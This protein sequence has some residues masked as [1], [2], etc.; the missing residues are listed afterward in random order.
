MKKFFVS[1]LLVIFVTS[2]FAGVQEKLEKFG[3]DNGKEY[4]KPFVTSY[5]TNFNSG[6]FNTA[7][8][9]KPFRF[10][11]MVNMMLAFVPDE[12]KTF[13]P[14]R[15]DLSME[16]NTQTYYLY[17]EPTGETA[18]VFGKDGGTII[19]NPDLD[20]I[21]GLDVSNLD[22]DLPNGGNLPAVPLMVPQLNVGLPAGNELMIRGLPKFEVNKDIGEVGF[23]GI[24]LKHSV[25]QYI[26]LIPIDIAI[27]GAYQ[28]MVVGD[29][30]ELNNFAVNAEISK[31]LLMWTLYGGL[32]YEST[33]LT[34]DY[35]TEIMFYNED[36]TSFDLQPLDIDFE[37]EGD[38]N[39]R[40]TFGVRYSLL[41][42]KLYADYTISKYSV[43]NAGIGI[44]F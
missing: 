8:V 42:L 20:A 41:L 44:S 9:L 24:G 37:I 29:I 3:E 18:T 22:I 15:P 23:W 36:T 26:P 16:Y 1:L 6:L 33:K 4:I 17:E 11:V 35:E 7:K 30:L 40:T 25:S 43:V 2:L 19:H 38:N 28:S 32:G 39:F 14:T 13:M 27:Q 5:G 34:A 21:P 31:K 12:D 10:G